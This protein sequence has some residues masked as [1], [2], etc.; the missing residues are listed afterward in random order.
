M[1]DEAYA[2][3]VQAVKLAPGYA[4]GCDKIIC[5]MLNAYALI[6][7][8][9][10]RMGQALLARAKVCEDKA[11][12]K[13]DG[14]SDDECTGMLEEADEYNEQA[15][16]A[17]NKASQITNEQEQRKEQQAQHMRKIVSSPSQGNSGPKKQQPRN[18]TRRKAGGGGK[19]SGGTGGTRSVK[20]N[21]AREQYEQEVA[22][23]QS[24]MLAEKAVGLATRAAITQGQKVMAAS[25]T[26][27][28]PIT[29]TLN[30]NA[31]ANANKSGGKNS[32]TTSNKNNSAAIGT[33]AVKAAGAAALTCAMQVGAQLGLQKLMFG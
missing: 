14:M 26:T 23:A 20:S 19:G 28:E 32:N 4:K 15:E 7:C 31:N 21:R 9:Y 13:K 27:T 33:A 17:M 1:P 29:V 6:Y 12:G 25:A 10:Y 2:D 24:E 30:A 16:W 22:M 8:R 11:Q 3:A 5:Q 18:H